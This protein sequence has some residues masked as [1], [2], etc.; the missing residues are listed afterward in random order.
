MKDIFILLT[1]LFCLIEQPLQ[2][3]SLHAVVQKF[4]DENNHFQKPADVWGGYTLEMAVEAL[5]NYSLVTS[6]TTWHDDIERFFHQRNYSFSDT[7]GYSSIP[8]SD[9]SFSWFLL[10]GD[11]SFIDPYLYESRK[12]MRSLVRTP[13]GAVCI[14]HQGK[15]YMLIDYLQVYGARMARAGYLSGD[16]TFFSECTRQF[17]LYRDILQYPNSGLYSQGRGWLSDTLAIS[18]SCWSR[19]Q[20]WLIRGMVSSLEFLPINSSY[21]KRLVA[22]LTEF[23]DA[24]LLKQSNDGMWH[25]LPCLSYEESY[26][27]VSGTALIAWY[28]AKAVKEG[29]LSGPE[30]NKAAR[31]AVNGIRKYIR[32]DGTIENVSHGPGTLRSVEEYKEQFVPGDKHGPPAVIYGLTAEY[33]LK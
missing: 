23:A 11:S 7:I 33:I 24:L 21:Y 13:E 25:T 19:G 12:M 1:F 2:S 14:N 22:I 29:Y 16:T 30:Y 9:P 28:L 17:E 6:D 8:F 10:K 18:P 20:G 31:K 3:Q 26:P 27:E 32:P 4:L 5:I 15:N